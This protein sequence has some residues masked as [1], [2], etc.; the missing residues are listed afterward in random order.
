MFRSASDDVISTLQK[1]AVT[2]NFHHYCVTKQNL[3]DFGLDDTWRVLSVNDDVNGLEFIS[4]ME[5]RR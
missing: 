1:E 5:H 4:T 3:T 2:P